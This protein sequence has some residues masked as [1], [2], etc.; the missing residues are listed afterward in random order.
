MISMANTGKPKSGGSQFFIVVADS[1][2]STV[3][4][5]SSGR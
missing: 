5:R 1:P 4:T 3:A 2:T